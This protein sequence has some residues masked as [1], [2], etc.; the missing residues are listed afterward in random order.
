MSDFVHL[1]THSSSSIKDGLISS[2]EMPKL[3]KAAGQN[4]I[5]L[6]DYNRMLTTIDFYEASEKSGVKPLIGLDVCVEADVTSPVD[7]TSENPAPSQYNRIVLLCQNKEGYQRLMQL[8][9]R[10]YLDNQKKGVPAIRQSWLRDEG[11][12]GLIALSGDMA[13]GEVAQA[14][15]MTDPQQARD[16]AIRALQFY[17]QAFGDR[18]YLEVQRYNQPQEDLQVDRL[19][20]LARSTRIPLVA[21]HPIQFATAD[22]FFVHEMRYCHANGEV[23]NNPGRAP[24][25]TAEQYFKSSEEMGD[26]FSDLPE[27]L[28]NTAAIAQRCNTKLD[29]GKNALPKFKTPD[30]STPEE[31]ITR[32]AREGME[33]RLRLDYPDPEVRARERARLDYDGRLARELSVI[34]PMDF[35]SYFLI[36]S[37]FITW[38][39]KQDIPV[40]PGRGSG[41]GSLVAYSLKITDINPMPFGLL[42]E[43]FLNPERVSMPDFDIDFAKAGRDRVIDFV[44]EE[45]GHESVVQISTLGTLAAKAALQAA[46]TAFGVNP[47]AKVTLSKLVPEDPPG[48]TL[49]DALYGNEKKGIPVATELRQRYETETE[50]HKLVNFAMKLEHLPVNVGKH[51]S[52]VLITPGPITGFSPLYYDPSTSK[53]VPVSQY[54]YRAVERAGPVK[55]DFLGLETL[56]IIDGAV[57]NI[58][59]R[60]DMQGRHFDLASLPLDDAKTFEQLIAGETVAVFQLEGGGMR[61]TVM[62]LRPDRFEDIIALVAMY[63]PGPMELIPTL[64]ARKHGLEEVVYPD[65]RVESILKETYGVMIYQEQ[66]MQMAQIIGG[67]TLG[68]ADLLRRA[69]GKKKPEE[70]AKERIKFREG[71]I[72]NGVDGAKAEAIFDNMEKFAGYGFNKSHAAAYALLAYQ[73]AYL[74]ANYPIEFYTSHINILSK[75]A[76]KHEKVEAAIA[77]ARANGVKILPP[78]INTPSVDFRPSMEGIRYGMSGLKY[79]GEKSV[80]AIVEARRDGPFV[81]YLDFF[82]RAA[83]SPHIN[84]RVV[85]SLIHVGAF[86]SIEPN[87]AMLAASLQ[88]FMDFSSKVAKRKAKEETVVREEEFEGLPPIEDPAVKPK[89]KPRTPPK[90]KDIVEPVLEPT[91]PWTTVERVTAEHKIAGFYI[92]GHPFDGFAEKFGGLQA[93]LPLAQVDKLDPEAE[94]GLRLVAGL[95]TRVYKGA[96]SNGGFYGR[97]SLSDG[98]T[99][100][101]IMAFSSAFEP[102]E[103]WVKDGAYLAAAVRI[104]KDNREGQDG[105]NIKVDHL[106]PVD[107]LY[108]VLVEKVHVAIKPDQ[109][110]RLDQVLSAHVRDPNAGPG[111][112]QAGVRLHLPDSENPGNFLVS[113]L[114]HYSLT[115]SAK[116]V[117][118]LEEALGSQCVKLTFRKRVELQP[119]PRQRKTKEFNNAN[120]NNRNRGNRPR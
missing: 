11:T 35:S 91:T 86:D 9:S 116:L 106:L 54:D 1:R 56:D 53:A 2:K 96:Q 17:R 89:R 113:D 47:Q 30:G 102:N 48:L 114:A 4:A 92:S 25:F 41:A 112:P 69:M 57:K 97:I 37:Q 79:V 13:N 87:R 24:R 12:D 84:K 94:S 16:T 117:Q 14:V 32:L 68:G 44:R 71:A 34:V 52:G 115:P 118:D 119:A 108:E 46:G 45:Y 75:D 64:V 28:A 101:S 80:D 40:G 6:T 19:V 26:L 85:E 49:H 107:K 39:K 33:E 55:F 109:L 66:V 63:R 27:A 51:A 7:E 83:I 73:T 110:D 78:D 90:P 10:A 111:G 95:V 88:K 20:K 105:N 21:T 67:Y 59:Q 15:L 76:Q 62:Q 93:A 8:L 23:I 50:I 104:E 72:K 29:L 43:R 42:F 65:P 70:M 103:S 22:D 36:V 100:Q 98:D 5:A 38:A 60:P 58:D 18:Y 74:K 3:A 81:S 77:D 99:N 61:R 31:Y 82:R 120:N